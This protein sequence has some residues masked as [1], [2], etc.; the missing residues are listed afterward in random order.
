M[1]S[2][3]YTTYLVMALVV[4]VGGFAAV[5]ITGARPKLGLDL[6]GGT[7]VILHAKSSEHVSKDV[8][9]KTASIIEA[10]RQRYRGNR[11]H[12]DALGIERHHR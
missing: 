1:R 3:R 7:S 6:A 4:C 2:K 10:R 12:G 9:A 11:G 5:M 8:L